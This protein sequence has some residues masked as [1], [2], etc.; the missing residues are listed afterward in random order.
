MFFACL[1]VL[2]PGRNTWLQRA[3]PP[4]ECCRSA[5]RQPLTAWDHS[6]KLAAALWLGKGEHLQGHPRPHPPHPCRRTRLVHKGFPRLMA[7]QSFTPARFGYSSFPPPFIPYQ[8]CWSICWYDTRPVTAVQPAPWQR[9]SEGWLFLP[10]S[11]GSWVSCCMRGTPD[12]HSTSTQGRITAR[13]KLPCFVKLFPP[14]WPSKAISMWAS[15][16]RTLI[17]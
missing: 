1:L 17:Q 2:S 3:H 15:E 12:Q 5:H 8:H 6:N 14:Q 11:P 9:I 4:P 10:G 7:L 16:K 13:E